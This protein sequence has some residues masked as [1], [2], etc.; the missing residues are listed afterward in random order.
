M[1]I[2]E[3]WNI[4]PLGDVGTFQRGGNFLKNDFVSSGYPCIHYGQIHMKFGAVTTKHLTCIPEVLAM[5]KAKIAK[6]GDLIIA[7]TS[8]DVEGS[9]KSTAWMGDYDI[10]IG[11]HAAIYHHT[12]NPIFVSYYF[13]SP[14][15]NKAKEAFTHGFKVVEIRPADIAKIPVAYP[16]P[17]EQQRIVDILDAEFAKIDALKA[18]A[19]QNMQNAQDLFQAALRKELEPKKGWKTYTLQEASTDSGQYG[20]SVSSKTFDG[21]RYLRITDITEDGELNDDAVSAD[22]DVVDDKYMLREGDIL[23]ARTGATVGKTLV[24]NSSMGRCSFAGY[25]IRYRPNTEI[26]LPRILYYV[27]HSSNYYKWVW[28]SQRQSTL[29]N[30]SAKLYNEYL[31]TVPTTSEQH[32]IIAEL[33]ELN[34]KCKSLQDNYTQTLA[35]CDDL[36]QALLRKAFNGEL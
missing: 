8:E 28:E 33:D 30:I 25:L 1:A 27:T 13:Q 23:F 10:A 17:T 12:L 34:T 16:S 26:V 3:G 15:F 36:K 11:A 2:K 21:I 22:I 6:K 19:E 24:Y 31:I 20:M 29:P 18:N 9:C 14:Q 4:K 32:T 35:L 5:S 7:I